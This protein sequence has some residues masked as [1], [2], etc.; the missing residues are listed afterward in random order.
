MSWK[1]NLIS[2]FCLSYTHIHMGCGGE[3]RRGEERRGE[4]RRG[5]ERRGEERARTQQEPI[6]IY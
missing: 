3:E 1:V 6:G 2:F 5:E 4:E